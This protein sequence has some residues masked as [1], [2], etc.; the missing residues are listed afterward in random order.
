MEVEQ[1][2]NKEFWNEKPVESSQPLTLFYCRWEK[3]HVKRYDTLTL[4]EIYS[5]LLIEFAVTRLVCL[6]ALALLT[7]IPV[8]LLLNSQSYHIVWQHNG[9]PEKICGDVWSCFVI[10]LVGGTR[11]IISITFWYAWS[12]TVEWEFGYLYFKANPN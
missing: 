6:F 3:E 2:N 11:D 8:S 1:H 10:L 5:T 4:R 9:E 7:G 12:E